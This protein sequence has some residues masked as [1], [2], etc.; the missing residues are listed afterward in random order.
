MSAMPSS[1]FD[2]KEVSVTTTTK[3]PIPTKTQ[4][5]TSRALDAGGAIEYT[6]GDTVTHGTAQWTKKEEEELVRRLDRGNFGQ[7]LSGG[8]LDD[9]DPSTNQYNYGMTIFYICFPCAV[10]RGALTN[11]RYCVLKKL[12]PDIGQVDGMVALCL[13]RSSLCVDDRVEPPLPCAPTAEGGVFSRADYSRSWPWPK[14]GSKRFLG[15]GGCPDWR[16]SRRRQT[17]SHGCCSVRTSEGCPSDFT[18]EAVFM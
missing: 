6:K 9:L 11:G 10:C 18:E 4:H 17:S 2:S 8:M 14:R 5:G 7:A 3:V 13:R 15:S 1:S 12:G 16:P